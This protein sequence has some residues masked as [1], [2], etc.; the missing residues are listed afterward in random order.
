MLVS[1]GLMLKSLMLLSQTD[2]GF[3]PDRVL[4]FRISLPGEAYAPER[5]APFLEQVLVK[6]QARPEVEAAA[7]GHCA[8]VSGGCNGTFAYFPDRPPVP[9]GREP[10]VGITWA[11]P[12]YFSTLGIRLTRGRPFSSRDREGQPKVVVI[13]ETAAKRFWPNEDAVGKRIA[14]GQGGFRDGEE[15]RI[16]CA[17]SAFGVFLKYATLRELSRRD[18]AR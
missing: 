5:R 14:V 18:Q 12:D 6:L 16:L 1:A 10:L 3:R 4:T 11:S 9:R 13:N 2:L 8:P 17:V 7:V 15:G